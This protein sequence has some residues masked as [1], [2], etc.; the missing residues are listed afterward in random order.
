MSLCKRCAHKYVCTFIDGFDDEQIE[1]CEFYAS[2]W[3]VKISDEDRKTKKREKCLNTYHQRKEQGLCVKCG[4]PAVDGK[5][6]CEKCLSKDREYQQNR[7]NRYREQGLCPCGKPK[8]MDKKLCYNCYVRSKVYAQEHRKPTYR[9]LGLCMLCGQNK[10]IDG[11]FYCAK[12]YE[13]KKNICLKALFND[14]GS[15]KYSNK[16]HL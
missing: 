7:K 11:Y 1:D 10:P 8:Y 13:I 6:K 12:C 3:K 16:N 14:D 5:S 9:E 4:Q 15:P 2:F